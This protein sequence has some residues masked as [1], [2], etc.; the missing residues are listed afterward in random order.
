MSQYI[1]D[2]FPRT[3]FYEIHMRYGKKENYQ[4]NPTT[5]QIF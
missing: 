5:I 3:F 4:Y 1:V 2:Y